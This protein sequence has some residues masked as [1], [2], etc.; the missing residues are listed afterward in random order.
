MFK[1][2]HVI[3]EFIRDDK[4]ENYCYPEEVV[5]KVFK[6]KNNYIYFNSNSNEQVSMALVDTIINK[7]IETQ[8]DNFTRTITDEIANT[9]TRF[10]IINDRISELTE[11]CNNKIESNE[12]VELST[13]VKKQL[14]DMTVV[15]NGENSSKEEALSKEAVEQM[16]TEQLQ[17]VHKYIQTEL[18]NITTNKSEIG[19]KPKLGTL[20]AL[21]EAGYTPKE[22]GELKN[23]ELI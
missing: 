18:Q 23:E 16:I 14:K 1:E 10:S 12:F 6:Y 15:S 7:I 13:F 5:G 2:I 3:P 19:T 20:F 22:I 8:L 11:T 21:K 9:E 17:L 4:D